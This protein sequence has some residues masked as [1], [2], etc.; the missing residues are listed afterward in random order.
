MHLSLSC[1]NSV[2]DFGEFSKLFHNFAGY[3]DSGI[4]GI[5]EQ[6]RHHRE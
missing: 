4:T 5:K 2:L 3:D 6:V 1:R